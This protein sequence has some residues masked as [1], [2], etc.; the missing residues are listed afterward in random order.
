MGKYARELRNM[1]ADYLEQRISARQYLKSK[2]K[3]RLLTMIQK[4]VLFMMLRSSKN[5]FSLFPSF[6]FTGGT[7]GCRTSTEPILATPTTAD[8]TL[9]MPT[10]PYLSR[11]FEMRKGKVAPPLPRRSSSPLAR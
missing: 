3:M 9:V 7:R 6:G 8:Q 5:S 11:S 1:V 2:S 10:K 4:L